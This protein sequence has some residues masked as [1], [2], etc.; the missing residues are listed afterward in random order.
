MVVVVEVRDATKE[1]PVKAGRQAGRW[2]GV[3]GR[4]RNDG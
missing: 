1:D 3:G 2:M 4:S